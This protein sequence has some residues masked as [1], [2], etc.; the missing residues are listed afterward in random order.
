MTTTSY[1][2]SSINVGSRRDASNRESMGLGIMLTNNTPEIDF[3]Q[4]AE[5][6]GLE[7]SNISNHTTAERL[8]EQMSHTHIN[9]RVA[10]QPPKPA[11]TLFTRLF[12]GI[13]AFMSTVDDSE[14][15][16][17]HQPK[18]Q[19]EDMLESYY[20]S[21]NREVPS[22]VYDP[23][24]DP[25]INIDNQLTSISA[26][27][28]DNTT[29]ASVDHNREDSGKPNS[30]STNSV[31]RSFAKLNISKLNRSQYSRDM[32]RPLARTSEPPFVGRNTNVSRPV[33]PA[34]LQS[35]QR[36]CR[37]QYLVGVQLVDSGNELSSSGENTP[38]TLE[39][40]TLPE[41]ALESIH[42]VST[43]DKS[44]TPASA[45]HRFG[46]RTPR[47]GLDMSRVLSRNRART[48]P[49]TPASSTLRE[50]NTNQRMPVIKLCYNGSNQNIL[51][52][53]PLPSWPENNFPGTS[54]CEN[55]SEISKL[56]SQSSATK[57]PKYRKKGFSVSLPV[58]ANP[59]KWRF[60]ASG[61]TQSSDSSD[62]P[63]SPRLHQHTTSTE[64]TNYN[65]TADF[66]NL[67]CAA[68]RP[69]KVKRLFKR[70]SAHP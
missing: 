57:F 25:P 63:I 11:P 59:S 58:W 3:Q 16:S 53:P 7:T 45:Y 20:I 23:P 36:T 29:S 13:S 64:S 52:T 35:S 48:Q 28:A 22:W 8:C 34:A 66:Q 49:N 2:G 67:Q 68:Q 18:S 41:S 4:M 56:K 26:Q 33:T 32:F 47:R 65:D 24:P 43:D 44:A 9:D 31:L 21:Q 10:P 61:N 37:E 1:M 51:P 12:G 38:M 69:N 39:E 14:C 50:I 27:S 40:H 55:T 30:V 70:H 19:I 42:L 60:G 62:N 17:S 46:R 6:M 54:T 5:S 15:S